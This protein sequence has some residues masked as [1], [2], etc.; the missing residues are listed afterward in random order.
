MYRLRLT[1]SLCVS[2]G[3]CQDVCAPDAIAMRVHG[4]ANVE[5]SVQAH[6]LLP[7]SRGAER[8]PEPMGTFPYLA[9]PERCDGCDACVRECPVGALTLFAAQAPAALGGR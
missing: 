6:L 3:I 1:A 9:R 7:A 8:P 2:C 5:G 4:A